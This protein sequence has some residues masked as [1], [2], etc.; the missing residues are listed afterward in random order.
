MPDGTDGL[1]ENIRT[2]RAANT[3]DVFCVHSEAADAFPANPE[4]KVAFLVNPEMHERQHG[5]GRTCCNLLCVLLPAA[6]NAALERHAHRSSDAPQLGNV[7][8]HDAVGVS[9][10]A[11]HERSTAQAQCEREGVGVSLKAAALKAAAVKG[12]SAAVSM[13]RSLA[14][15]VRD[16][17]STPLSTLLLHTCCPHQMRQALARKDASLTGPGRENEEAL[18]GAAMLQPARVHA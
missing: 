2:C 18:V 6:A 3:K 14:Y 12:D 16:W 10:K 8:R 5:A 7:G 4:A 13:T 11:A 9:L 17:L 1:C 15:P